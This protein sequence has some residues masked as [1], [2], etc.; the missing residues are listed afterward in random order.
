MAP[1]IDT[2]VH[3]NGNANPFKPTSLSEGSGLVLEP[4]SV[5]IDSDFLKFEAATSQPLALDNTKPNSPLSALLVSS[6]Y[7]EPGHLLDLA[8]LDVPN[9]LFAKAL[10]VLRPI[11]SD[12]ATAPYE[13]SLNWTTVLGTLQQLAETE[14]YQWKEQS[15]YVVIFRS[16]LNPSVDGELLRQL[17]FESHGEA[18]SSGGLL[19]YWFGSPNAERRNLATCLWRSKEDARK[20]GLGPW[21]K[22]ARAAARDIYAE[23]TFSSHRFTVGDGV[24]TW[25]FEDWVEKVES[26]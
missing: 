21:H 24:A 10:T 23:I 14:H 6:P 18:T 7:N 11:R 9:R 22:K 8:T 1:G 15:F 3:L 13:E 25:S 2:S 5:P 19:K 17:D 12:Y 26:E 16:K 4:T 20:G